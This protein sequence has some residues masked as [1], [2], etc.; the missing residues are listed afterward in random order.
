[1]SSSQVLIDGFTAA[2]A[3]LL[4]DD[5]PLNA[6]S[7][8]A[9]HLF[10]LPDISVLRPYFELYAVKLPCPSSADA[11]CDQP[12]LAIQF[13]SSELCTIFEIHRIPTDQPQRTPN[14][15]TVPKVLLTVT[16][17]H[18]VQCMTALVLVVL[19]RPDNIGEWRM[20][21]P[22]IA[23]VKIVIATVILD[24]YQYWMHRWM[25]VNRALYR[26]FH[27]V[28]HELTVP[29][30]FGALYN[31]PV[32]GFLMDTIGGALPSLILNMHPWTSAIFYS[33]S[34]LKTVD[35]H[36]GYAW[37][38]SPASLFN[39]NGAKYH[40]IHHWGKG[41]MYNFAQPYYT[42]WD[43][44]MGTEYEGAMQ[45][46]KLAREAENVKDAKASL[47]FR[48]FTPTYSDDDEPDTDKVASSAAAAAAGRKMKAAVR[49][50]GSAAAADAAAAAAFLPSK[51]AGAGIRKR[52]RK[53]S[54]AED[55]AGTTSSAE[56][57][58]DSGNGAG[59][60]E[61]S[62][63]STAV[64]TEGALRSSKRVQNKKRI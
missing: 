15:V 9:L 37:A 33:M 61:R 19:T 50:A 12:P 43:H 55:K 34:T 14:K 39:A 22:A 25:H 51:P 24:T 27:R 45:R 59:S 36:C 31:H 6:N 41:R 35:D 62:K 38:W 8:R 5:H 48:E 17:Q 11:R 21:S 26:A 32:E 53:S 40:D 49:A 44:W 60:P 18:V 3:A 64:S 47:S 58:D 20:E 52:G 54:I 28:H 56:L 16:F 1:M 4:S 57:V 42:F 46:K 7:S 23:A 10:S 30:A 29:F 13:L 2:F 63:H